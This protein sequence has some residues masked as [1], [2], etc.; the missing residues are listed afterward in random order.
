MALS[1]GVKR[2]WREDDH[3]PTSSAG[4]K[5]DGAIPP[6]PHVLTVGEIYLPLMDLGVNLLLYIIPDTNLLS[7]SDGISYSAVIESEAA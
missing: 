6:L 3:S 1:P 7:H 5:N 2:Q 4:V